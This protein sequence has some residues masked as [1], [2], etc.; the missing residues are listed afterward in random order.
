MYHLTFIHLK[1]SAS[2]T[3]LF[4]TCLFILSI[5]FCLSVLFFIF[6]IHFFSSFFSIFITFCSF[7]SLYLCETAIAFFIVLCMD[8]DLSIFLSFLHNVSLH[9]M[10]LYFEIGFVCAWR[11]LISLSAI[12]SRRHNNS[13]YD[14]KP[15]YFN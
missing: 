8:V 3:V 10:Q 6:F 12:T 4:I 9:L 13:V 2:Q 14:N 7:P 1:R 5:S 15:P 11:F